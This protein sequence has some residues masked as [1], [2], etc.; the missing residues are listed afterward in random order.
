MNGKTL[1]IDETQ[2]RSTV[3]DLL[4]EYELEAT[5][6]DV[7]I[8]KERAEDD[9]AIG[10]NDYLDTITKREVKVAYLMLPNINTPLG[11]LIANTKL[12]TS[13]FDFKQMKEKNWKMLS[14]DSAVE[15]V[16]DDN[17]FPLY[18]GSSLWTCECSEDFI[19]TQF[20]SKCSKCGTEVRWNTQKTRMIKELF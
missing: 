2:V 1:L 16:K 10:F 3:I 13:D 15:T 7:D 17:A 12:D 11:I 20:K 6:K 8:L 9:D 19:H 14:T 18:L 4:N 5:E